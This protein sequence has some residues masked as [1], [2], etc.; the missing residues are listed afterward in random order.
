VL[1]A[2]FAVNVWT[3]NEPADMQRLL[4]LGVTG[5]I[6]DTPDVLRGMV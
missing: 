2:G 4:A 3:V 1:R 5:I 6:T